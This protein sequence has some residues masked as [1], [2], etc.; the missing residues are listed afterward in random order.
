MRFPDTS[1]ESLGER[2]S[3]GSRTL[4][5][6]KKVYE[7]FGSRAAFEEK[8]RQWQEEGRRVTWTMIMRHVEKRLP[9]GDPEKAKITLGRQITEVETLARKL[10]EHA[11]DLQERVADYNGDRKDEAAGVIAKAREVSSDTKYLTEHLTLEKPARQENPVYLDYI[12]S[13][14]CLACRAPAPCQPHHL[15]RGGTGTRGPDAFTVPLCA[16]CHGLLHNKPEWEFWDKVVGMNPWKAVAE[17]MLAF[18]EGSALPAGVE[19]PVDFEYDE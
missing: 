16:R 8:I 13:K 11:T 15:D 10:E 5:R 12:R 3:V 4:Y 19:V 2:S 9:T 7:H 1:V 6:A 14:D 18:Y 17:R